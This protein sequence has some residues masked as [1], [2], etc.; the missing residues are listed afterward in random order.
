MQKS[1]DKAVADGDKSFTDKDYQNALTAYKSAGALKP[2]E[3]YPKQKITEVQG[4][5]DKDKAEGQRYQEAIAQAD[6]SFTDKKYQEALDAY[7]K[8]SGIKPAEKYPQEQITKVNQLIA[9]QKKLDDDYQKL[10]VDA[11]VQFRASKYTE[12]RKLYSDAGALKP[13]EK[14]PKDKITEIDGIIADLQSK[15]QNYTKHISEGDAGFAA[16]KYDEAIAAYNS[17][18]KIKPTEA[19][20][21]SQIDKINSLVVEIKKQDADYT[22]AVAAADKSLAANKYDDAITDYKKALTLKPSEKY[23]QDKIAEAEKKIADLKALQQAYD[24]AIAD[25]DK[26]LSGK[27][28]VN[29]L[30]SYKSAGDLKPSE[31]YPKQKI[32]EVQAIMDKDKAEGQRYQEAIAQADKSFTDKKY[33]EAIT[34]YQNALTIKSAEKYPVDQIVKINQLIADEKKLDDNYDK[35]MADA[36]VQ[37]K[38]GKFDEAKSLYNN[39]LALKPSEKLPKDKIAE[40]DSLLADKQKKDQD[41]SKSISEGDGLLADKK[42]EAAITAYN[43]ALTVKPSEQYPTTQIDKINKLIAEQKKLD[44]DYQSEIAVADNLFDSKKYTEAITAYK[45]ATALKPSEKYPVDRIA[46]TEKDIAD[47]KAQQDSYDK[48]IAEGD[49]KMIAKDYDNALA[50]FKSAVSIKPA[51]EY[52]AKKITEVQTIIDKQKAEAASYQEAI[53]LADKYFKSEKYS[54]ALEPYQRATTINP[55]EKYP[56]DQIAAINKLLAEQKKLDDDYQKL[57][58]DADDLAKATKYT[59]ARALYNNAST[60]KPTEKLPKDKMGEMDGII[61]A[62]KQKDENYSKAIN[63]ASEQYTAKNFT[64]ALKSYE[65]AL[66]IKPAEKMPQERIASIKAELKAIDDNYAKAIALG[67]SKLASKDLMEALNA[68]QNALEIKVNED[69]PKSKIA[70]INTALANQ[71]EEQEKLYASYVSSGDQAFA[72]KDYAVAKSSFTKAGGIKPAEAYP[73]QQLVII[74][75]II[76]DLEIARKTEY[77]KA[78]GQA[79]KL[80]NTKIFDQAIDAYEVAAKINPDDN[81]PGLQISKIRKYMTDHAI[82]DLYSEPLVINEG[83]EKKFTFA[84]I[85]PR[86]RKNNYIL[87]KVRSTGKTTPKVYLNYGQGNLKNGG[88][89]LRSIDK[90]TISDYLIR[91][92]VQ[93]KWY[94]EDN[95]WISLYVEIGDIE[96]TKVQ[97][98]AGDE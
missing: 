20:P 89:V 42:F 16:K 48:A 4:I 6:K 76:E 64:G 73:K 40:I 66:A 10:L 53:T 36:D 1:Y 32:T 82:Q 83:G 2:T 7:Q 60:L 47:M 29:A 51:E 80:Y 70:E 38:A 74:N 54:E 81:Y 27:D 19:Y 35:A 91:I 78:L 5:L 26:S 67:D 31:A 69:Y 9:E 17:A 59:E 28:Y 79:D 71:K 21:Q 8:A 97:I 61:A 50:A 56:K 15:E 34:S 44:E 84:S 43:H 12:A 13:I 33:A 93:D 63:T 14:L 98:A 39:A 24:K 58:T 95:N 96:I 23:P 11:D 87:L 30:A 37:F 52:P 65:D 77:T 22:A 85:E 55:S 41:Y 92:S 72:N 94:R 25:A 45:K 90:N 46:E 88:I 3:A 68:Y 86:L 75:K 62:L 49:K 57:L 18:L